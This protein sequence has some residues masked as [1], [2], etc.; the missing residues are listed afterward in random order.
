MPWH[1]ARVKPTAWEV[2]PTSR[3]ETSSVGGYAEAVG[4]EVRSLA[5][6]PYFD[7][8]LAESD[9]LLLAHQEALQ[10]Y[11]GRALKWSVVSAMFD[12]PD[13]RA[14]MRVYDGIVGSTPP[15]PW[16]AVKPMH[17]L[18]NRLRAYCSAFAFAKMTSRR[19]LVLWEPDVHTQT[20]FDD[21]FEPPDDDTVQVMGTFEP[22]MFPADHWRKF[23][24]MTSEKARKRNPVAADEQGR[25]LYVVTA[26]RL[27]TSPPLDTGL[28]RRCGP[29]PH[30]YL[31]L[32]TVT[33]RY[34]PYTGGAGRRPTDSRKARPC[35]SRRPERTRR[36]SLEKTAP[37][38]DRLSPGASP[39]C[40][41][42]ARCARCS[43]PPTAP[44][45]PFPAGWAFT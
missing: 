18:A 36:R 12:L 7:E 44:T 8:S 23:D 4:C 38:R 35:H 13:M 19:L 26:Y 24:H 20:R 27:E 30:R 39:R 1:V 32:P 43:F 45:A 14:L 37:S 10:A 11:S 34:L 21:L 15:Q 16:L 2:A 41:R 33:Y 3:V 6:P 17:G 9:E 29:A 25:S 22:G 5:R 40:G 28:Y 42:W 31:P